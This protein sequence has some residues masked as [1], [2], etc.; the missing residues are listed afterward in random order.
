MIARARWQPSDGREEGVWA[1]R[2][3]TDLVGGDEEVFLAVA[4]DV[5]HLEVEERTNRL[6]DNL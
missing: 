4:I 3:E 2:A 6:V 5:G 1:V